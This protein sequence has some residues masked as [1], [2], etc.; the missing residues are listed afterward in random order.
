MLTG[1]YLGALSY[2]P[3]LCLH[4]ERRAVA[5]FAHPVA[6]HF[7]QAFKDAKAKELP[8][9]LTRLYKMPG[10]TFR[11]GKFLMACVRELRQRMWF[12]PCLFSYTDPS[13]RHSEQ[14]DLAHS[15]AVYRACNFVALGASRATDK[16]IAAD[17]T[18][19]SSPQC[20]RIH[21]TKSR[22]KLQ[23][24]GLTLIKGEPK[25]LFVLPMRWKLQRIIDTLGG[26][27]QKQYQAC[28]EDTGGH[29]PSEHGATP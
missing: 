21:K 1:H 3:V 5:V 9:E 6:W 11:T 29:H 20:Y 18:P 10:E 2:S 16:W 22:A 4:Y 7:K 25:E 12:T 24:L 15:G 17:G 27:Y 19:L 28:R 14:P 8:L 13:I 26:R 23:A